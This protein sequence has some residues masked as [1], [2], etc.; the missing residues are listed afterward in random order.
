MEK[1]PT[2]IS[3][4]NIIGWLWGIS[5]AG[6]ILMG[7]TKERYDVATLFSISLLISIPPT[8]KRIETWLNVKFSPATQVAIALGA[9]FYGIYYSELTKNFRTK[10][11]PTSTTQDTPPLQGTMKRWLYESEEDKMTSKKI[12][13]ASVIANELLQFNFPYNGGSTAILNIRKK[14]GVTDMYLTI[15]KGQFNS[16]YDG[17]YIRLRFDNNPP[18]KYSFSPAS[19]A[20]T[21]V[22]FINSVNE[23]ISKLKKSKTLIIETEFYNE[24][25]RQIEFG[26]QGLEWE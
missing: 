21:D 5:V 8:R 13:Y 9:F 24:G 14:G 26:V 6:Y 16:T 3:L 10:E 25:I 2:R 15:S 20:S 1:Q 17:G 22:I 19:D 7:I 23:I 12:K 18:K 4:R 11:Q